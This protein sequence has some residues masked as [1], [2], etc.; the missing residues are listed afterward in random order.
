VQRA[1]GSASRIGREYV[2]EDENVHRMSLRVVPVHPRPACSVA[3]RGAVSAAC[4]LIRRALDTA[5]L[6][7]NEDA[8]AQARAARFE[9]PVAPLS[10][11]AHILSA[12]ARHDMLARDAAG[13]LSRAAG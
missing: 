12:A 1:K 11:F 13:A 9:W 2:C 8:D 4:L 7:C 5:P 3:V 6:R 10:R